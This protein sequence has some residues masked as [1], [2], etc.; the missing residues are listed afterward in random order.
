LLRKTTTG[1]QTLYKKQPYFSSGFAGNNMNKKS[2]FVFFLCFFAVLPSQ[3][4]VPY[5]LN[6]EYLASAASALAAQERTINSD[7]IVRKYLFQPAPAQCIKK[8]LVI[9]L[10]GGEMSAEIAK[11]FEYGGLWTNRALKN[12]FAVAFPEGK[13]NVG[14]PSKH[15]WNDCRKLQA[16]PGDGGIFATEPSY[17]TWDDVQ[18][19]RD[20]IAELKNTDGIDTTRVYAVG[21]SN[22]GMM[23]FRLAAE[24]GD[25]F[26][27][28]APLISAD[29]VLS[30]CPNPSI[31]HPMIFTYGTAD[32]QM[33][34][35]G[36]C[37][38]DDGTCSKGQAKSAQDTINRWANFLSGSTTPSAL[39]TIPD[40]HPEDGTQ[41]FQSDYTN[42]GKVIF[43]V[44]RV[45]GGGHSEP[46]DVIRGPG[47]NIDRPSVDYI[48]EF[49]G[50]SIPTP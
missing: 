33:P 46:S 5:P 2:I 41:Q 13:P 6:G 21:G 50:L 7:G 40:I 36:G 44:V 34:P 31:R 32:D 20:L 30:E 16:T 19:I 3:L 10:H 43:R 24:A 12:G 4:F 37:I 1:Y 22:G 11:N 28:F 25:L 17:S 42:A 39:T 49:F 29:V 38:A 23:T 27:G 8:P 47:Y 15:N 35:A 18:F 26:A 45:Q 48:T 9:V 14:A